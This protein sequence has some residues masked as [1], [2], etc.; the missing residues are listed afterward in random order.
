MDQELDCL[1]RIKKMPEEI[2]REIFE[3]IPGI[4]K[5]FL[6]KTFY[7]KYHNLITR[8]IEKRNLYDNFIRSVTRQDLEFVFW[9]AITE[10][11]NVWLKPK[12][13]IYKNKKFSNY[14][15]QIESLCIETEST[16][17]R[18]IMQEVFEGV[19]LMSKNQHKKNIVKFIKREW[20]N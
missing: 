15:E 19:A 18:S 4:V 9:Q 5:A 13:H 11:I 17:C 14:A 6:N 12:K 7:K 8:R 2:E 1:S 16:K 3:Y 10:K 20:T